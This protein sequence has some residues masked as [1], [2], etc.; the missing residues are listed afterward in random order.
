MGKIGKCCCTCECLTLEELPSI[1]IAGMTSGSWVETEC[2]WI[3]TFSF[4]TQPATVTICTDPVLDESVETIL[5][6]D[7]YIFKAPLPPLFTEEQDFPLPLEYCCEADPVLVGTKEAKCRFFVQTKLK[8]SYRPKEIEV[9]ASRQVVNC[10]GVESCKLVLVANYKYDLNTIELQD[11]GGDDAF[12]TAHD[13]NAV[14][15]EYQDDPPA[16]CSDDYTDPFGPDIDCGDDLFLPSTVVMFTR[17]KIYDQWPTGSELFDNSA[18][19]DEGCDLSICSDDEF[20]ESICIIAQ[21]GDSG[22]DC[23]A[24]VLAEQTF[25]PANQCD[26]ISQQYIYTCGEIPTVVNVGQNEPD[27]RLCPEFSRTY[28]SIPAQDSLCENKTIC[29]SSNSSTS[30]FFQQ[31]LLNV[32]ASIPCVVGISPPPAEC[33]HED[34]C[35]NTW[36]GVF[37]GSGFDDVT[38]YS[39]TRTI[40]NN[41]RSVCISAPTWTIVFA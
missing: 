30:G 3:K 38:S 35:G 11:A 33:S 27:D 24:G 6:S 31:A 36:G 5:N 4:T 9:K 37:Y 15:F 18:V 16:I 28:L 14:C 34:P 39:Y 19:L 21:P 22:F 20:N 2:C 26:P 1:T 13:Q 32:N 41:T 17:V 7:H 29:L 25:R 12:S 10:D 40:N 23:P 8:V